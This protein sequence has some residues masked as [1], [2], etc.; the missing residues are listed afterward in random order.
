MITI[1]N[2]QLTSEAVQALNNLIGMDINSVPGFKLMRIIKEISSLVEDKLKIEKKIFNKWV[3][4]DINGNP[5]LVYDDNGI[6]I[7]NAVKI[8]DVSK[9]NEEMSEL[10]DIATTIP[11]SKIKFEDLGLETVK[12]KDIIKIDFIFE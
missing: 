9:F 1:K 5:S 10:M 2:L 11:N 3:E 4:K 12:I 6:L 8:L 7:E